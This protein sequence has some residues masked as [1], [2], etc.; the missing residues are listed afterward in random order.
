MPTAASPVL[1][2][3]V[4]FETVT[5]KPNAVL[6]SKSCTWPVGLAPEDVTAT[7]KAKLLLVD[8]CFA[9]V[10]VKVVCEATCVPPPLLPP[11]H[12]KV[13][14]NT[15]S[16]PKPS[17]ARRF[18]RARKPGNRMRNMEARPEPALSDHKAVRWGP[19][20]FVGGIAIAAV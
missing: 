2:E 7:V 17:A 5:G 11:P 19:L 14:L 20:E 1:I 16:S 3:A 9:L 10:T 13:K 8:A 4:P 15:Q 12:P 6:P 18:F